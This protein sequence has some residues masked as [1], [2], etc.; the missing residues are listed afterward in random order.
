MKYELVVF[1]VSHTLSMLSLGMLS[2]GMLLLFICNYS[3]IQ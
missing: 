2:L 1:S 3:V